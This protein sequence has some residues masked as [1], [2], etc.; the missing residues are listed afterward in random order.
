VLFPDGSIEYQYG[1]LVGD[2]TS[3]TIGIENPTGDAGM[4]VVH[5]APYLHDHMAIRFSRT[6]AAA[7]W[8]GLDSFVGILA[9]GASATLTVQLNA[10]E[11]AAGSYTG[12]ITLNTSEPG[13]YEIPVTLVVGSPGLDAPVLGIA[14]LASSQVRLSWAPIAGAS[15]YSIYSAPTVS[16]P[17]SL[18]T[19][20]PAS[21]QDVV[22][23][24]TATQVFRVTAT[25]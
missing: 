22:V 10:Q 2:L 1:E 19:T 14:L 12:S 23:P 3:A 17:W 6:D 5:T 4:Q 13:S 8:L 7:P 20:A 11:L 16:G 21:P 15:G 18:L 25:N 24:G 9:G